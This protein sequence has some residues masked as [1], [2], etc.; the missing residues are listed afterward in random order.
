MTINEYTKPTDKPTKINR[1]SK[2]GYS[3]TPRS[4]FGGDECYK[5][6]QFIEL[7]ISYFALNMEEPDRVTIYFTE[8][9]NQITTKLQASIYYD[10]CLASGRHEI[11]AV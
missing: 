10:N 7:N 2:V 1:S 8:D 6:L 9:H 3:R 4:N 5:R 11:S